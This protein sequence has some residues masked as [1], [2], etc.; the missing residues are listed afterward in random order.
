MDI[1]KSAFVLKY[2]EKW[3]EEWIKF[4]PNF[5][6]LNRISEHCP[7]K[8]MLSRQQ[9]NEVLKLMTPSKRIMAQTSGRTELHYN[10]IPIRVKKT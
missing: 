1:A 2:G 4:R 3:E 7:D 6:W 8:I 5:D 9:Y 10:G